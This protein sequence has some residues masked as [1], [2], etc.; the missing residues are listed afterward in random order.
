MAYLYMVQNGAQGTNA[1]TAAPVKQP[2]G[3]AIRTMLQL[4]PATGYPMKIIEWG[5]SFDG[6]AAA[7][8]GQIELVDTLTVFGTLT[9]A[10]ALGDIMPYGGVSPANTAG[11]SGVPLNLS[12]ATTAFASAAGTEGS[13]AASCTYFDLQMIAPTSQYIKQFPLG[14]EPYVPAGHALRVRATFGTTV[15]MYC[16]VVVEF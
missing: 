6:S 2:T 13:V 4:A 1:P 7:T 16:Y 10:L 15:N 14:R 5:C 3:T 9:T 12:T 11:S 8:P